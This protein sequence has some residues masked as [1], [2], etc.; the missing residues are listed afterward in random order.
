MQFLVI[1]LRH[2]SRYTHTYTHIYSIYLHMAIKEVNGKESSFVFGW[3]GIFSDQFLWNAYDLHLPDFT[4]RVSLAPSLTWLCLPFRFFLVLTW[5]QALKVFLIHLVMVMTCRP[6]LKML[7]DI[8]QSKRKQHRVATAPKQLLTWWCHLSR[9][10]HVFMCM[11]MWSI[12]TFT[13]S[14][15]C[16]LTSKGKKMDSTRKRENEGKISKWN[17]TAAGLAWVSPLIQEDSSSVFYLSFWQW[18]IENDSLMSI[19]KGFNIWTV[20]THSGTKLWMVY[21]N[22]CSFCN[23]SRL[24]IHLYRAI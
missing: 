11:C 15:V 4:V 6:M 14:M 24:K 13:Q 22:M 23:Y 21:V 12:T 7:N 1:L 18:S 8:G 20:L 17:T 16:A 9:S 10:A 2:F 19:L 5:P 3:C